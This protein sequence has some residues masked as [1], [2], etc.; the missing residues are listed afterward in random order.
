MAQQIEESLFKAIK[1][2]D[3]KAFADLMDKTQCG[4]YRLGRF[5]VLSL[6]YLYKSRRLI[7]SYEQMFLE[8]TNY[9]A[10]SEPLEVSK[11]FS[12][13]AGKCLR[14]YMNEV[15]SPLEML[16]IL[17]K[18][19]HLKRA[20]LM[21]KPMSSEI[22]GRLKSIY[23]IKYSLNIRFEIDG[24]VIDRRPLSYREKKNI[25][26]VCLCLFLAVVIAV[27]VPVTAVSLIPKPIE[28]EATKLKHIDFD[29]EKEYVLKQD[30]VVPENFAVDKVNCTIIG[31]GH[32]FILGKG[33][34][35]GRLN[36]K[37]SDLTIESLGDAIFKTV[38]ENAVIDNVTVNVNADITT[39]EESA[40][41]ALENYG[42]IE[43]VTLNVKG[44]LKAV[45]KDSAST[46]ELNFGGIVLQNNVYNSKI[47]GAIKNCQLNYSQFSLIGETGAN[48]VFGGVAGINNAYLQECKV[49]GEINSDTFD[50]AGICAVNNGLLTKNTNEA[51][52]S[53]TS[54]DT[55]WNPIVCG[56]VFR[57]NYVVDNC[58]NSG[59]ISSFSTCGRFDIEEDTEPAASAV[60]IAYLNRGTTTAA[61]IKNSVNSGEINCGSQYRN[62]YAAGICLSTSGAIESCKNSGA[63]TV[64]TD[65]DLEIYVGGI[66]A[67]ANGDIYKSV[68]QGVISATGKG[69]A[70]IGGISAQSIALLSNCVSTGDITATAKT[71]YAGGI[72]GFSEVMS[73]GYYIYFGSAERCIS[74]SK[75]N[76]ASTD[77][78]PAYVGGIVGYVREEEF[79]L[80]NSM[81]Y[82]G[83]CVTDCYFVG[84]Y[85]SENSYFGNIVGVCGVNVYEK[86]SY[87]SSATEYINFHGSFYID[88]AFNSFGATLNGEDE[89]VAVEGKGATSATKEEI[90][91]YE[92]YKAILKNCNLN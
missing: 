55:E 9:N 56:I 63:L 8:I 44:K 3:L 28:G 10:L 4:A 11:K 33:A 87:T 91:N 21:T 15:V 48:A 54:A 50:I 74:Q 53:Q 14:L 92:T 23:F 86:N 37:L 70:Y 2:D 42:T 40:F 25:A 85:L 13:K 79:D 73:G 82:L 76:V 41:V 89:F 51:D 45:A 12:A 72:M 7:S 77:G 49:K 27:G 24:I 83:G 19:K 81:Q 16:L 71:V 5:P 35:F 17:D 90:E 65:S 43:N 75:I 46:G 67:I 52:L 6:M 60:G 59:A 39:S 69:K 64:K 36:G 26:T 62:I 78:S 84:E 58:K 68:N 22:K 29:S 88:N 38:G 61:Y 32:K 47:A 66:V 1:N 30:I 31:E 34:S 18:T 20:Y 57:N 80:G